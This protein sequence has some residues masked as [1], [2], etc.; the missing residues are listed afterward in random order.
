MEAIEEPKIYP[1]YGVKNEYTL[2]D[3]T[4]GSYIYM[5]TYWSNDFV[6]ACA[7]DITNGELL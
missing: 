5:N 6:D 4:D 7:D 2:G 3:G 1:I